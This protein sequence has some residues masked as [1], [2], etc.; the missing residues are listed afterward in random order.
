VRTLLGSERRRVSMRP[1]LLGQAE[2]SWAACVRR[3]G[4]RGSGP[5]GR[6]RPKTVNQA[7]EKKERA[8]ANSKTGP[9]RRK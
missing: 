3:R 6:Q 2:P 1:T 8:W 4:K 7:K 9:K 5:V